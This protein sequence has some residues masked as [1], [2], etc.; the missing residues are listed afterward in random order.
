MKD[1]S[2]YGLS[3]ENLGRLLAM[4]LKNGDAEEGLGSGH[5]TGEV[6]QHMLS[7]ELP[8]D[9]AMPD[10]VP[11]VLNRPCREL[12]PVANQTVHDLLLSPGTDAGIIET[13]KEYGKQL[14]RRAGSEAVREA[15][16]TTYY[17]AI[18]SVLVFHQHKI[19]HH[20]YERLKKSFTVLKRKPWVWP[21][22]KDLFQKAQ[23]F[24]RQ[25]KKVTR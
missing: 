14:A 3:P 6:L 8:L 13:V 11:A 23:A 9:P 10:S 22:L 1:E 17:A 19:S 4:G 18:A 12:R 5:A 16:T 25:C 20:S 24:C 15:A 21:E 2:T 7:R